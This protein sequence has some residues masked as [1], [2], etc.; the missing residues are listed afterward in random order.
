MTLFK[1]FSQRTIDFMWNIRLNNEKVWF[2]A[3]KEDYINDFYN[4]MKALAQVVFD[5]IEE[6]YPDSGLKLKVSRIYRDARRVRDG[7]PYRDLLWFAL[8]KPIDGEWSASPVFWFELNPESWNYGFGY[9]AKAINM[10]K[11]RARIDKNPEKFEKLIAL[12]DKQTDIK[13]EGDEYARK[14]VAPTDKTASWYN[15]KHVMLTYGKKNGEEIF[16]PDFADRISNAFK[17]MMP[18][19]DYFETIDKDPDPKKE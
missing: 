5:R 14:K 8:E 11:F 16:S 15:K 2:D 17:F 6:D 10:A 13:L 1:G 4:P 19:Y 3:H 7:K 18:F 9:F 12:L